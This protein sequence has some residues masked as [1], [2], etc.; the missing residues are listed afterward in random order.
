MDAQGYALRSRCD[1][2]C[3]GDAPLEL[4]GF[5]GRTAP[6]ALDA[7]GARALYDAAYEA[8]AAAGFALTSEPVVLTPSEKL[9]HIIRESQRLALADEGGESEA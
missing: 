5:D 2:V 6:V 4:V 1:L 9:L 7:A 3:E 8:A